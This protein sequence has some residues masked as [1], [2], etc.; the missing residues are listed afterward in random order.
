MAAPSA[1]AALEI[2]DGLEQLNPDAVEE[3][4]RLYLGRS[5]L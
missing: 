4:I 5:T 3:F 2:R 1:D